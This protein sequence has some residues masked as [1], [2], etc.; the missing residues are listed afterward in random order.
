VNARVVRDQ[1]KRARAIPDLDARL[2]HELGLGLDQPRPAAD[3]FDRESA[4]ELELAADLE[5]LASPR[6]GEAHAALA[7]PLRGRQALLHQDLGEVGIAAVLGDARHVV[8]ELLLGVGA[9]VGV[10][11]LV[12][13]QVGI[14]V[15][16]SSGP[17]YA[18]RN[19]PR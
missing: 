14:S 1:G 7:H 16:R 6:G 11:D 18:S 8:E 2:L 10:G 12:G 3:R 19:S 15:F 9:E 4:P 13:R 17:L 5:R